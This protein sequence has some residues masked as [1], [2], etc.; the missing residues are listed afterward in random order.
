MITFLN[1]ITS[2][3]D[4]AKAII[5]NDKNEKQ[6]LIKSIELKAEFEK[7]KNT[8]LDKPFESLVKEVEEL[9]KQSENIGKAKN[10]IDEAINRMYKNYITVIQAKL[11]KFNIDKLTRK[12]DKLEDN[13]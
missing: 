10:K 4:A 2:L 3:N 11:D 1:M 8:Y 12:L 7:L 6:T 13:E 5:L 9:T